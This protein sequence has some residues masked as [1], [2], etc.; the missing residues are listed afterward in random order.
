MKDSAYALLNRAVDARDPGLLQ[1]LN[2]MPRCIPSEK[3]GREQ[4]AWAPGRIGFESAEA[5]WAVIFL[6]EPERRVVEP[7]EVAPPAL[8]A[9]YAKRW[10]DAYV[11]YMADTSESRNAGWG[12]PTTAKEKNAIQRSVKTLLDFLAPERAKSRSERAPVRIESYRTPSGCVLQAPTAALSVAWFPG[13]A[14][15]SDL[16]QLHVVLWRG[17]VT[18]R[19]GGVPRESATVLR[20]WTLRPVAV[21]SD[22]LRWREEGDGAEYDIEGLADHCLALLN[23]QVQADDPTDSATPTT[24]R[25]RD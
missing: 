4:A 7:F 16:G 8:G 17:A 21:S 18:R 5:P 15:T 22:V 14:S 10:C 12:G 24:P 19:G 13:A 3:R 1:V 9:H 6:M 11:Q 23:E 2:P 20:E 25:R